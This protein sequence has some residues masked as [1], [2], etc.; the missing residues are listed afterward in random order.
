MWLGISAYSPLVHF[1]HCNIKD[2]WTHISWVSWNDYTW[3][4]EKAKTSIQRPSKK[5][6]IR[7]CEGPFSTT[8]YM[9]FLKVWRVLFTLKTKCLRFILS[10]ISHHPLRELLNYR[11]CLTIYLSIPRWNRSS[12]YQVLQ[13]KQNRLRYISWWPNGIPF[14]SASSKAKFI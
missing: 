14:N 5:S 1:L 3:K 10:L 11:R 6:R 8:K 2:K 9:K 12:W 4:Y 13:K 7:H